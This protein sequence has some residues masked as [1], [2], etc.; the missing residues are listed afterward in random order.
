MHDSLRVSAN[1][2]DGFAGDHQTPFSVPLIVQLSSEWQFQITSKPSKDFGQASTL[3]A[4][5]N[6]VGTARIWQIWHGGCLDV[7]F[8]GGGKTRRVY[9]DNRS[10]RGFPH[11][12]FHQAERFSEL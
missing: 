5:W 12:K 2:V 9:A 10:S 3:L 7:F 4:S 1:F 6:L 8:E 11:I